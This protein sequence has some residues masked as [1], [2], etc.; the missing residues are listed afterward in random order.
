ML[1]I[2]VVAGLGNLPKDLDPLVG[3]FNALVSTFRFK[4]PHPQVDFLFS[5]F[6]AHIP[7]IGMN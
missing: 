7:I 6:H 2:R 5:D 4:M 3:Q 1:G